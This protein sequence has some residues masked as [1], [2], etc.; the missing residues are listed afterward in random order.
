MELPVPVLPESPDGADPAH[1]ADHV[2]PAHPAGRSDP[3]GNDALMEHP[4]LA[5]LEAMFRNL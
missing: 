2:D 5:M 1:P 4:Y 3:A